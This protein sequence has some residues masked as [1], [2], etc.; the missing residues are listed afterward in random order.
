VRNVRRRCAT[1]GHPSTTVGSRGPRPQDR[2]A[3]LGVRSGAWSSGAVRFAGLS[4][5]RPDP[6]AR[7]RRLQKGVIPGEHRPGVRR[8][9]R[10]ASPG[11]TGGRPR[12]RTLGGSKASKRA[13]RP[14]AGEP[15]DVCGRRVDSRGNSRERSAVS[16]RAGS[17]VPFRRSRSW[18]SC[19]RRGCGPARNGKPRDERTAPRRRHDRVRTRK[20]AGGRR[21]A[22]RLSERGRL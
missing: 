14:C 11:S 13:V 5:D 1:G 6:R 20:G 9:G 16:A 22:V 19:P 2:S 4:R 8:E 17:C 12:E 3:A 10:G 7:W 15:G 18:A 21:K